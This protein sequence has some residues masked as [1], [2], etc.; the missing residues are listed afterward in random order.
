MNPSTRPFVGKDKEVPGDPVTTFENVT[1]GSG[2]PEPAAATVEVPFTITDPA[3]TDLTV[4]LAFPNPEDYDLELCKMQ[5]GSC[6][7]F[8]AGNTAEGSSGGFVGA[9][10]HIEATKEAHGDLTGD[11]VAR[12]ISFASATNDWTLTTLASKPGSVTIEPGHREAWTMTCE[13]PEG[14]VLAE[15]QLFIDRGQQSKVDF[16]GAC[17]AKGGKKKK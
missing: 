4:D 13:T 5:N 2:E 14:D 17:A 9:Q 7:P 10:E 3:T 6:E 1:E 11:Y 8:G 15:R 16:A 12:V